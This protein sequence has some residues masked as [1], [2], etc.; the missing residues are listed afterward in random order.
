MMII[1]N[2]ASSTPTSRTV[3]LGFFS[4]VSF[5]L[6]L[7]VPAIPPMA[8]MSLLILSSSCS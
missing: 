6:L 1:K 4:L 5:E 3:H 7:M 2:T 8:N